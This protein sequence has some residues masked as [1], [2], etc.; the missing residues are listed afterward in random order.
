M[1]IHKI[2]FLRHQQAIVEIE[3]PDDDPDSAMD[4][5]VDK[6]HLYM[7]T[8]GDAD[9]TNAIWETTLIEP[10]DVGG[11]PVEGSGDDL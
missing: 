9:L 6:A 1:T 8:E 5:A 4:I 10:V 11:E 7:G 3:T 2:T